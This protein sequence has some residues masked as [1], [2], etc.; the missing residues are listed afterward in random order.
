MKKKK[1]GKIKSNKG[2]REVM[3]LGDFAIKVNSVEGHIGQS[4]VLT[5]VHSQQD[6]INWTTVATAST[7]IDRQQLVGF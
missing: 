1:T 4:L 3:E 6:W 2:E 7:P 5:C